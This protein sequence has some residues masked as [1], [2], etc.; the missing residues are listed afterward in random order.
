MIKHGS[1]ALILGCMFSGKTS[2]LINRYNRYTI[3]GKS[4]IMIKHSHDNRYS[5]EQIVTHD[6]I[7]VVAEI[8]E[9]LYEMDRKVDKYDAVF[10]DEIQ[11]YKDGH[12]FCDKWANEG[13]IVVAC[14]L[15]GRSDRQPFEVIS[16]LLPLVDD[17]TYLTAICRDNGENAVYSKR[18]SEDKG[19]IVIGGADKYCAV[20]RKNFFEFDNQHYLNEF[21]NYVD[22][23]GLREELSNRIKYGFENYI[24]KHNPDNGRIVFNDV[25]NDLVLHSSKKIDL[26]NK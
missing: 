9:H 24:K 14:G 17:L 15:N 22:V 5:S 23:C 20:D 11:F 13:K 16:R 1:I 25:L 6:G 21:D 10:I 2:E 4:C 8:C 19:A 18:V 12:I 26:R 7:N 3:G